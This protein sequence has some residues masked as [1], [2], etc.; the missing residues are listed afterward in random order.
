MSTIIPSDQDRLNEAI[1]LV[2]VHKAISCRTCKY[3][4]W[5]RVVGEPGSDHIRA[6]G[7]CRI[8][9][10]A[11]SD[12]IDPITSHPFGTW[13]STQDEDWC[14]EWLATATTA[15]EDAD[16]PKLFAAFF[17]SLSIRARKVLET[18]NALTRKEL[19]RT[20]GG[21]LRDVKNC[22]DSTVDEISAASEHFFGSPI[23][24]WLPKYEGK[25]PSD[26]NDPELFEHLL[27]SLGWAVVK[28]FRK[29]KI[30][31]WKE[32]STRTRVE[33]YMLRGIGTVTADRIIARVREIY[34][35]TLPQGDPA[36]YSAGRS[37][38]S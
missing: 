2:P 23:L 30:T 24:G 36:K 32:L 13:P 15:T 10:P 22:G 35:V 38:N 9:R 4:S 26:P 27:R 3:W 25:P 16:D 37:G 17:A 12:R 20:T 21:M 28:A 5:R 7:L 11:L 33:L 1:D 19:S 6:M 31:N 34:G 14:G 29:A 18:V 8:A